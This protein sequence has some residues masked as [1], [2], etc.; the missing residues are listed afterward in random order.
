MLNDPVSIINGGVSTAL[1]YMCVCVCARFMLLAK[2]QALRKFAVGA[3]YIV[4]S[5]IHYASPLDVCY[6]S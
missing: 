3:F 6:L 2:D 1:T 5:T 4:S